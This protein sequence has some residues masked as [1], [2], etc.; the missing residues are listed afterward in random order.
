MNRYTPT[1]LW[2]VAC[3]VFILLNWSCAATKGGP[4]IYYP[5][6]DTSFKV[7]KYK[8]NF[9]NMIFPKGNQKLTQYCAAHH[10]WEDIR[11]IYRLTGE[12]YGW[13]YRVSKS[14][15]PL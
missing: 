8:D 1:L 5:L 7:H 14:K 6:I 10:Q 11:P 3:L 9:K 12:E 2:L 4:R 13:H 15:K